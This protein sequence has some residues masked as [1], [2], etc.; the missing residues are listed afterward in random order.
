M[1]EESNPFRV[2]VACGV[3]SLESFPPFESKRPVLLCVPLCF[4]VFYRS[5]TQL[6][7]RAGSNTPLRPAPLLPLFPLR[8]RTCSLAHPENLSTFFPK[9][10]GL[11]RSQ[12]MQVGRVT[13]CAPPPVNPR[14]RPAKDCPPC[15]FCFIVSQMHN[16]TKKIGLGQGLLLCEPTSLE[17]MLQ[18]V[19]RPE[20]PKG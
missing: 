19:P 10:V 14:V 1:K 5:Q 18:H 13:P 9:K 17:F 11:C 15:Q 2:C 20:Q 7:H 4:C 8:E 3:G 12:T 6:A 16:P